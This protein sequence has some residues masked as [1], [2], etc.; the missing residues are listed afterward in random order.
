[1]NDQIRIPVSMPALLRAARRAYGGA[2]RAD[3][4]RAGYDDIPRNGLYV[5]GALANHDTPLSEIIR[6]LG[7]SKQAA[8]QLVDTL[9]SRGYLEREV[10]AEDR[11]RLTIRLSAR[12]EDAAIIMREAVKRI[13]TR[14]AQRVSREWIDHTRATLLAL[15]GDDHES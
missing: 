11:R 13:D 5:L 7:V 1:M 9:V 15:I 8:G 12:G 4:D 3:L 14:L 6:Y 10:D 2:I